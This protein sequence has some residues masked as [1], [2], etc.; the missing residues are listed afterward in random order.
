MRQPLFSFSGPPVIRRNVHK[1]AL[2]GDV[3]VV[4]LFGILAAKDFAQTAHVAVSYAR[5]LRLDE[6]SAF[7]G[8]R[9][10]DI[11]CNQ[12]NNSSVCRSPGAALFWLSADE[13][14][15][16]FFIDLPNFL[17]SVNIRLINAFCPAAAA[18]V[19]PGTE[20]TVYSASAPQRLVNNSD[21]FFPCSIFDQ[22]GAHF[23]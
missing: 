13:R 17:Y 3:V 6:C 7:V 20:F 15:A 19:T 11:R 10:S 18:I 2:P 22:Y 14:R 4:S 23:L 16:E 5:I 21:P 9:I 12:H 8:C 1:G